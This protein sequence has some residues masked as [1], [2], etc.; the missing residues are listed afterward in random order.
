MVRSGADLGVAWDGDFDRCFLYDNEGNFVDSYYLI[1][2]LAEYCLKQE[3]GAPVL[4]DP[5]LTWCTIESV[6]KLNGEPLLCRTGHVFLK[7]MMK[8]TG[9]VYGGEMSGHHY[10]KKFGNCDSGMLPWLIILTVLK[11][12]NISLQDLI[13]EAKQNFPISGE[14]NRTVEDADRVLEKVRSHYEP[15]A[16]TSSDIDGVSLEF[17]TWRFNLR[18][19]NTEPLI[20]LNVE[21][22]GDETLVNEKTEELL[23]LI[24]SL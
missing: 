19:S 24:E 18:K 14:I 4:Y 9:A 12:K 20:R 11:E 7:Q 21:S 2:P 5:R 23:G 8:E 10:F 17:G 1:G 13:E 22:R 16:T 6:K 15:Q 3:P